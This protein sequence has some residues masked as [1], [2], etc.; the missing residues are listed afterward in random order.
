MENKYAYRLVPEWNSA[1]RIIENCCYDQL[2][3]QGDQT[4]LVG[5]FDKGNEKIGLLLCM[6]HEHPKILDFT[7]AEFE[8]LL[9]AVNLSKTKGQQA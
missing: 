1:F 9:Q 3:Y 8:A 7:E 6:C 4:G 2:V 5:R